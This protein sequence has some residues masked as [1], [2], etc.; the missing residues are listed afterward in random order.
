MVLRFV[1]L[2]LPGAMLVGCGDRGTEI[3][4]TGA[5]FPAPLYA[6]WIALYNRSRKHVHIHYLPVGSGGGIR[7]ITNREV[8]F[9]ASDAPLNESETKRLPAPVLHIPTAMGPVV[10][11]YNLPGLKGELTL[12]AETIAGIYLGDIKRW[13]DPKIAALNPGLDLPELEIRPAHRADSSGTTYIFTDYLSAVSER[14]SGKV[15]RGKVVAWPAG[16]NWEGDGNDGVAHRVLLL[17]GGVGYLELRYAENA[18]L[19]YATIVNRD[20]KRVRPSDESVQ[21]AEENSPSV[22]GTLIKPSMVNAPGAGSYPISSYTYLLVYEDLRY[23][24]SPSR[25]TALTEFLEWILS[26]G[27]ELAPDLHYVPLPLPVREE[28]RELV[29]GIR[30]HKMEEVH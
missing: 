9:G 14:W 4:G 23:L 12:D 15:G 29:T 17:P 18:G 6:R 5:T 20:G 22:L 24:E 25:E 19:K 10:I 7:A 3:T 2:I 16:E 28:A 11:A 30:H 1:L 8:D 13:N 26:E 21:A 27:Q